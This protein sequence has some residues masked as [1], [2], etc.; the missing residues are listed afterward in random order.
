[1]GKIWNIILY[2][3]SFKNMI[4]NAHK[5]PRLLSALLVT[6]FASFLCMYFKNIY[7]FVK[8]T[9]IEVQNQEVV[10]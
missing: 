1:M 7:L 3:F 2:C 8:N 5:L 4:P 10:T 9:A 6:V